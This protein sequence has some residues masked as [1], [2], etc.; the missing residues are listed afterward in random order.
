MNEVCGRVSVQIPHSISRIGSRPRLEPVFPLG[1]IP[2]TWSSQC[3]CLLGSAQAKQG[4]TSQKLASISTF[5]SKR[6]S[7]GAWM[8]RRHQL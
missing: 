8:N 5:M 1:A 3:L 6:V 2:K 7:H 4:P